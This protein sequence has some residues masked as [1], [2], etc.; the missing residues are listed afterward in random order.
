[1]RAAVLL[2]ALAACTPEVLTDTYFC[3]PDGTCPEGQACNGP[4]NRCVN[5][6][7]AEGF[8]CGDTSLKTEPDDTAAQ[9]HVLA[10][11]TCSVPFKNDNCMLDGNDAEDWAT[12][13]STCSGAADANIVI[14]FPVAFERLAIELWDLD[15]MTKLDDDAECSN[16][17]QVALEARC[18]THAVAEGGHYGIKIRPAGDGNC[19]GN[20]SYNRYTLSVLLSKP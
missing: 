8:T 2:I 20:C 15:T 3:G 4:D 13:Q 12:F 19:D 1:M 11:L 7:S 9:A 14:K 18:I 17:G 6:S 5:A 16:G 10:G